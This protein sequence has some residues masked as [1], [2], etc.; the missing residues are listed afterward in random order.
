MY[1]DNQALYFSIFFN[2]KVYFKINTFLINQC[3]QLKFLSLYNIKVEIISF[4][5]K[6]DGITQVSVGAI[7]VNYQIDIVPTH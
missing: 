7:K 6:I 3:C 2:S 1:I 4:D 5:S